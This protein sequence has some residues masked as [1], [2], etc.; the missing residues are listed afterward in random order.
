MQYDR[1]DFLDMV[2]YQIYPRSFC[3]SNG[4]GI[5]DIRG[6]IGKLD[7]LKDLGVN[8]VWLSPCFKS[9]KCDNGYDIS[10]YREIDP[11]YG[12]LDD[13][14]ELIAE[15]HTRGIKLFMDLVANHTSS[16]HEWFKQA[17]T[18]KDNPYHDYYIWEKTPPN[19]WT[20][21]F[22]GSAW[23]YNESTDEYYLHSF[24]IGQ[25]DL[26]WE[27]PKVREEMCAVVDFWVDLGV[28]GFRCDVLDYIGKSY[29]KNLMAGD[30]SMHPY[31]KQLFGR[32]KVKRVFTVGECGSNAV[33]GVLAKDIN[34]ICGK[35]RGELKTTFQFEHF[36]VGRKGRW[37][38]TP[39][40]IDEITAILS[41]WQEFSLKYDYLYPLF[42]DNHDQPQ[43]ISRL[44]N[45]REL[46]YEC[47]TAYAATFY[48][49]KGI[50]FIYQGQEYGSASA[51]Y[52][53]AESFNDIETV[54]YYK[55]CEQ[56]KAL[57]RY[58]VL[59]QLN[60][61]TRDNTRHPFAWNGDK[62]NGYG[63]G[64]NSPW[65]KFNSRSDEINLA[66]DMTA[67]KSVF[68]F[69]KKLFAYRKDSEVVRRGDFEEINKI[70]DGYKGYFAFKRRL[71][72]KE[73]V[74]VIN[75][76]REQSIALPIRESEYKLA[77]NNYTDYKAFNS[78][79][80]AFEVTVYE[81]I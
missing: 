49:L 9:P 44:G 32:D 33:E 47:A 56:T 18:S 46:R 27:N 2:V 76:D 19:E 55:S 40:A 59:N 14:K 64:S 51:R 37:I 65:I 45:D 26:N 12:T 30:E 29:E 28:D 67:E 36:G 69:Y 3:D 20:C 78:F 61:G 7:Y 52:Y 22:G 68:R 17:R 21:C 63:F 24:A 60:Y 34:D 73:I 1:N 39:Y 38:K 4:D 42:T 50:P 71:G 58:E 72:D 57:P 25:P 11:D 77:L 13:V 23:E 16:E 79:Y 31:I 10:D 70:N 8:A 54:N 74:A 80:R 15:M 41:R 53:D 75:F 6:I 48:L 66:D 43:Y 35:D 5:G 81:K 62:G